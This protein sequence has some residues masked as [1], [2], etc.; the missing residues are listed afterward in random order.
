MLPY[1]TC[2]QSILRAKKLN[3][4]TVGCVVSCV[5]GGLSRYVLLLILRLLGPNDRLVAAYD[6]LVRAYYRLPAANDK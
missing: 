1:G 4:P 3:L 6:G 5:D 2:R